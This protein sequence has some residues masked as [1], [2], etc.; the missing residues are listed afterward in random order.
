MPAG[1]VCILWNH[2]VG[3]MVVA[4]PESWRIVCTV[5]YARPPGNGLG[6]HAQ[7]GPR[8]EAKAPQYCRPALLRASR[9][10]LQM[11]PRKVHL[12]SS[13]S[14]R[15]APARRAALIAVCAT[16]H[17]DA[18]AALVVLSAP[19]TPLLGVSC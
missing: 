15:R 4:L 10:Q 13:S 11:L 9:P 19:P 8:G 12:P 16:A 7:L 1:A 5:P 17:R 6:D 3:Y 18:A 14:S 2:A